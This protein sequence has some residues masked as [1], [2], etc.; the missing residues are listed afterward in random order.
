MKK[1]DH[2]QRVELA[3][4]RISKSTSKSKSKLTLRQ[5]KIASLIGTS[6]V[7]VGASAGITAAV[8]IEAQKDRTLVYPDM[9]H[10]MRAADYVY[11]DAK[12]EVREEYVGSQKVVYAKQGPV[13]FVSNYSRLMN[14]EKIQ[15]WLEWFYNDVS[16]GPEISTL[17][18]ISFLSGV[19]A[20]NGVITLG[21]H[22]SSRDSSTIVLSPDVQTASSV[23]TNT[24]QAL[25]YHMFTNMPT[26]TNVLFP[27]AQTAYGDMAYRM[28]N[29]KKYLSEIAKTRSGDKVPV[30]FANTFGSLMTRHAALWK[31]GKAVYRGTPGSEINHLLPPAAKAI[32]HLREPRAGETG[33][34]KDGTMYRV[35]DLIEYAARGWTAASFT[36]KIRWLDL[37][38]IDKG[39]RSAWRTIFGITEN[40]ENKNRVDALFNNFINTP[41]FKSTITLNG[42]STELKLD[43]ATTI[44]SDGNVKPEWE[45]FLKFKKITAPGHGSTLYKLTGF[46]EQDTNTEHYH[47]RTIA[48]L[49]EYWDEKDLTEKVEVKKA[50]SE[51]LGMANPIQMNTKEEKMAAVLSVLYFYLSHSTVSGGVVGKAALGDKIL[52]ETYKELLNMNSNQIENINA[53]YLFKHIDLNG[54]FVKKLGYDQNDINVLKDRKVNINNW[55]TE[56]AHHLDTKYQSGHTLANGRRIPGIKVWK[57]HDTMYDAIVRRASQDIMY[58]VSH[59][60]GHHTTLFQAENISAYDGVD[61]IGTNTG[62]TAANHPPVV[63]NAEVI[64]KPD[65]TSLVSGEK[66]GI[67]RDAFSAHPYF[68]NIMDR[69]SD[70]DS[71]TDVSVQMYND[72]LNID[73]QTTILSNTV[74]LLEPGIE[75]FR[76]Y[77]TFQVAPQY[78]GETVTGFNSKDVSIEFSKQIVR[79]IIQAYKDNKILTSSDWHFPEDVNTLEKAYATLGTINSDANEFQG[80]GGPVEFPDDITKLKSYIQKG[81]DQDQTWYASEKYKYAGSDIDPLADKT[82]A[83]SPYVFPLL[84]EMYSDLESYGF[85]DVEVAAIRKA[86]QDIYLSDPTIAEHDPASLNKYEIHVHLVNNPVAWNAKVKAKLA[87]FKSANSSLY[88]K[89]MFAIPKANQYISWMNYAIAVE[90]GSGGWEKPD[91]IA[92]PDAHVYY[93]YSD[94]QLAFLDAFRSYYGKHPASA[95]IN[96]FVGTYIDS[97]LVNLNT[98]TATKKWEFKTG[99]TIPDKNEFNMGSFGFF[100]KKMQEKI[101]DVNGNPI[102]PTGERWSRTIFEQAGETTKKVFDG[103]FSRNHSYSNFVYDANG[104][105][106]KLDL[107][108]GNTIDDKFFIWQL[109]IA[110]FRNTRDLASGYTEFESLLKATESAPVEIAVGNKTYKLSLDPHFVEDIIKPNFSTDANV[111]PNKGGML[112]PMNDGPQSVGAVVYVFNKPEDQ[113]AYRTTFSTVAP[114]TTPPSSYLR[115]TTY[116]AETLTRTLNQIGFTQFPELPSTFSA[117]LDGDRTR[118]QSFGV[119]I[120]NNNI[121]TGT[122]G[123]HDTVDNSLTT[124]GQSVID[125]FKKYLGTDKELSS[126]V[127]NYQSGK[128]TFIGYNDHKNQYKALVFTDLNGNIINKT[129]MIYGVDNYHYYRNYMDPSSV[130]KLL[131]N[132]CSWMTEFM[133]LGNWKNTLLRE[134][135]YKIKFWE[136][137]DGDDVIDGGELIP[138]LNKQVTGDGQ[139]N[140]NGK[141]DATAEIVGN[142]ET[143]RPYEGTTSEQTAYKNAEYIFRVTNILL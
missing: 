38:S 93:Q 9:A 54:S 28:I 109:F 101:V 75:N 6:V 130:E 13:N 102:D 80:N 36:D 81:M 107:D 56:L 100:L 57:E 58:T 31:S 22:T 50:F 5:K 115:Y 119:K 117:Y 126:I 89:I 139:L 68:Q 65:L 121:V 136:D 41:F 123:A 61:T 79:P 34:Q 69:A 96:T 111:N 137:K 98:A 35:Q 62:A 112:L 53:D 135:N 20:D 124:T 24:N 99:T 12:P 120:Y 141:T 1:L 45:D 11:G 128:Y 60:Y 66:Y 49:F 67:F 82:T 129:K 127:R 90:D 32:S 4:S 8:V 116:Y 51:L 15:D 16:W 103:L 131:T 44:A 95:D 87:A 88:Q 72:R 118:F 74:N 55:Y 37:V 114:G 18:N 143:P 92:H 86:V 70:G 17:S 46:E 30:D 122:G 59:E 85:T 42:F 39:S 33:Y 83:N 2:E 48:K 27:G 64:V 71:R 84:L 29:E 40:T 108:Y 132:R 138:L 23:E 76:I 94:S 105:K 142:P 25:A 19:Q 77:E 140:S 78:F 7:A 125:M 14:K 133:P 3:K 91:A 26:L 106:H 134:G 73:F 113:A 47:I 43:D 52:Y 97:T 63:G 104:V 21:Y 10:E 110:L